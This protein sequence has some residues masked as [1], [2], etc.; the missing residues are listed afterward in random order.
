MTMKNLRCSKSRGLLAAFLLAGLSAASLNAQTTI[1][2]LSSTVGGKWSDNA[3]WEGGVFPNGTDQIANMGNATANRTVVLDNLSISSIKGLTFAQTSAFDNIVEIRR[4]VGITDSIS[5]AASSGRAVLY[6]NTSTATLTAASGTY[7]ANTGTSNNP[8]TAHGGI[9]VN[10]GGALMFGKIRNDSSTDIIQ[11]QLSG[12]VTINGGELI[13]QNAVRTNANST[14]VTYRMDG[15]VSMSSGKIEVGAASLNTGTAI[16]NSNLQINGSLA[17]SG[18]DTLLHLFSVT[19]AVK[20]LA[21]NSI[22]FGGNLFIDMATGAA[23]GD[24]FLLFSANSGLSGSFGSVTLSGMNESFD[25]QGGGLWTT[26][27]DGLAYAFSEATG[28]LSITAVPEPSAVA[29]LAGAG[30]LAFVGVYRR[31]KI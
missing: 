22:S 26:N 4:R 17:L 6:I 21:T 31:R 29:I 15:D 12:G 20:V 30:V 3:N 10:S 9:T 14:R 16:T 18:G 1:N 11:R 27:L 13:V 8:L 24:T 25:N 28:Y 19:D 2:W 5:L 23:A 7:Q